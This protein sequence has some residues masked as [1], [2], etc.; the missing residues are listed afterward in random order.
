MFPCETINV[1]KL[2][3]HTHTIFSYT[4]KKKKNFFRNFNMSISA[5]EIPS[6][7]MD[8]YVVLDGL[9]RGVTACM[10]VG[11]VFVEIHPCCERVAIFRAS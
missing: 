6:T 7:K 9:R 11:G 4:K 3:S 2:I 8:Y 5:T 1:L 10:G